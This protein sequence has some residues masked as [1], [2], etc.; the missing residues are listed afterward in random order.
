[1]DNLG[2]IGRCLMDN[3]EGNQAAHLYSIWWLSTIGDC[4]SKNAAETYT[5]RGHSAPASRKYDEILYLLFC[6]FCICVHLEKAEVHQICPQ[7]SSKFL[8]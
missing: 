1:M 3:W 8:V 2:K 5:R 7:K 6:N 4:R